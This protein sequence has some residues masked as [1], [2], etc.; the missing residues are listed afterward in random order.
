LEKKGNT[1]ITETPVDL[2]PYLDKDIEITGSFVPSQG[3]TTGI[4][5]KLCVKGKCSVSPGPGYW[6]ASPLKIKTIRLK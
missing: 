5:K 6:Y 3:A 1:S 4:D 2:T